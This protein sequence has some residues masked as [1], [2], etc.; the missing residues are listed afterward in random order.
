MRKLMMLLC[1]AFFLSAPVLGQSSAVFD[2]G[3]ILEV[4][5]GADL[6]ADVVTIYGEV[7]GGGTINGIPVPITLVSFT[8]Q[9]LPH[10]HGVELEWVTASEINNYGF[11]VQRAPDTLSAFQRVPNSFLPGHGTTIEPH[12]YSF[13]DTTVTPGRWAYR[14][15]QLDLDGTVHYSDAVLVN[16]LTAVREAEIPKAFALQQNYPNPFNPSTVIKYEVPHTEHVSLEVFN[17]LGQR[18][19]ALVNEQQEAGYYEVRFR[20]EN[21]ASGV[22][23]YRFHAGSFVET[24]KLVL[25]R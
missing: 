1:V 23:F 12:T 14:L 8:A 20:N 7:L 18:V 25:L 2:A 13:T 10:G 9:V 6:S 21:L 24:R 3:T 19:A 11:Y 17:A 22:Y 15:E 16:V 4:H 5:V